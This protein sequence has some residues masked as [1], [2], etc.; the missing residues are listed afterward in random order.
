MSNACTCGASLTSANMCPCHFGAYTLCMRLIFLTFSL[1]CPV[2]VPAARRRP[3]EKQVPGILEHASCA[4]C[5][6]VVFFPICVEA[7]MLNTSTTPCYGVVHVGGFVE[8]TTPQR[9]Y[10]STLLACMQYCCVCVFFS[11]HNCKKTCAEST[12]VWCC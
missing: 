7:G 4:S 2:S 12:Q 5:L 10:H 11:G 1:V 9:V 8:R 6:F 3:Q